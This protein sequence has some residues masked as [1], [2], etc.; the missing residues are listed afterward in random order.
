MRAIPTILTTSKEEFVSQI[1]LF[2]QYF[3][4]IQLDIADGKLVPNKT[5]QIQEMVDLIEEKKITIDA[6]TVFDFHLMVEDFESELKDIQKLADLGIVVG[7]VLIN[8][9]KSPQ[10]SQIQ[11]SYPFAIGLDIFPDVHIAE[12]ARKYNL[13]T[14]SGIQIMTVSPGFQGSPFLPDMLTKIQQLRE[15]NYS[16]EILIDG[17]VNN[18]TLS[19]I[20]SHAYRPDILCLGSYL[21][22]AGDELKARVSH[23]ANLS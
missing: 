4:R 8:A 20:Q 16:G 15:H 22:K 1:H 2:Q 19:I 14:L 9:K 5:T 17:G 7:L 10:V 11:R 21:T 18:D 23:L 12:I 3:S 13:N 6:K